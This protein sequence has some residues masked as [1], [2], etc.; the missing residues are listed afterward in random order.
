MFD[1][2]KKTYARVILE[3]GVGLTPGQTLFLDIGVEQCEF[4]RIITEEAFALG[5]DDVVVIWRDAAIEGRRAA[6]QNELDRDYVFP[7]PDEGYLDRKVADSAALLRIDSPDFE[8]A[9]ALTAEQLS[10]MSAESR[11]L[12][13]A[14][15]KNP[16]ASTCV[17]CVPNP[18]WAQKVFPDK[19]EEVAMRQLWEN[20]FQC[21]RI[22]TPDPFR[23]WEDYVAF[24]KARK[25]ILNEKKYRS[26]RYHSAKTHLELDLAPSEEWF[27]GYMETA[28]GKRFIPNVPTEEIFTVPHKYS[29]NGYVTSTLPLNVQGRVIGPF[30]L[31]FERGKVTAWRCENGGDVLEAILSTDD[32]ASYLGEV[33]LVD[34]ASPIAKTGKIFYTTLF[35]ENASCHLALGMGG[36]P[37]LPEEEREKLG[38]NTSTQHVDFMIGSDDLH[39]EGLLPNG[40]WED[41][42][43]G[44]HWVGAYRMDA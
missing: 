21:A 40:D 12:S 25:A 4:A 11:R 34:Q 10:M 41:I 27:G 22:N 37:F 7:F 33:A 39:I 24:T 32:G 5:A 9:A 43:V 23:A 28:S 13:M 19:N 44:G 6:R 14:F 16:E 29:A 18:A 31:T 1:L 30:T 8:S 15:R 38:L 36:A 20:I 42:F 3:K 35:D 2:R 26:L 17:A